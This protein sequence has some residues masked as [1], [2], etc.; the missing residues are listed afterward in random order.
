MRLTRLAPAQALFLL[1][2]L[3]TACG[4]GGTRDGQKK[5]APAGPLVAPPAPST[6]APAPRAHVPL[7]RVG[8][9][10]DGSAIALARVG[11][12]A[13][14][15]VA[16]EDDAAIRAVDLETKEEVSS[17]A[18]GGRPA[19]MLVGADGK[20]YVALRDEQAIGVFEAAAD[21]GGALDEVGRIRTTVEPLALAT[22]GDDAT[23]VVV[24]GWGHALEAFTFA[25]R[26]RKAAVDLAREPRALT[27]S[28]DGKTAFVAHASAGHLST[29]DLEAK[30]L[31]KID[32]GMS[33]WSERRSRFRGEP[34]MLD[35]QIAASSVEGDFDD[36]PPVF[37]CGTSRFRTVRFPARVARQGFALAKVQTKLGERILAPHTA[38]ATGDALVT[39]SGYGGGGLDLEDMP[40]ELFD[41]DV[42]DPAK[43]ART[44]GEAGRVA[45]DKRFGPDACHLPR[46]AVADASRGSLFVTCLGVDKVIEYDATDATPTGTVKRRF[47][48]PG[49]P[50]A[51]ALDREGGRAVV[52]ASFDRTVRVI[53]LGDAGDD[54]KRAG[55]AN[56]A[57]GKPKAPPKAKGQGELVKADAIPSIALGAP[58]SPLP[59]EVALGRRLFHAAADPK[60]SRDGRACASCHPDGR[61]D[62]LVWSTPDGPRQTIMLAGRI[63]RGAPFGWL[64]S[65]KSIK[66]HVTITMR[67]LKGSGVGDGEL[68]AIAAYLNAM[69]APPR[70]TTA[71]LGPK[72]ERGKE[73]FQSSLLGCSS[74]HAEKNGFTDLDVHDVASATE[75][76]T[77]RTFLAPSLRFIGGSAP[78]FH[79][80][81]YATLEE[82]LEKNTKM[83]DT[84]S[85]S[86]DDRAALAAFLRTL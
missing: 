65:H 53:A 7:V 49:G 41:I 73:L 30:S 32:L 40:S 21:A 55:S 31:E 23:L 14:A 11:A 38:V 2:G 5:E 57:K 86:P 19:Q 72:E 20:L 29:I 27:L 62:A 69:K 50:T 9:A 4:S 10:R 22:T 42:I 36:G 74:C 44:T 61:D 58:R 46:A 79:D 56:D 25:T 3:S 85:L 80:G 26:E 39:S 6:P 48:V 37:R 63:G 34:F 76:D 15:Y 43:R 16:D 1:L 33:G 52:L 75:A 66:E 18:L 77:K 81:R 70:V 78:Y 82:L 68:E 12:R 51:I 84:R 45:V 67:N 71:A 83:G 13:L 17:T 24:S 59:A 54:A 28:S 64:G 8:D 60:I 47:E 35:F